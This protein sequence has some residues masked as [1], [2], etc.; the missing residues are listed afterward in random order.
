M[1]D[2]LTRILNG[3]PDG[4]GREALRNILAPIVDRLSCQ[5]TATAG[6]V[7]KA[8]GS[9]LAKTGASAC[10]GMVQGRPFTIDAATD[11]PALA[12][13]ISANK[14]NVFCFFIDLV[15]TRT[16]LMGTEAASRGNVKFPPF[17]EGK[18]L[19]GYLVITH[20]ATFVGGTTAL[21]TATT[22]YVSP[23]GACDPSALV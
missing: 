21:D 23:M 1:N 14:F 9:A 4:S 17:P 3:V 18:T 12:G 6:L 7:I 19:V 5:V 22:E 15:G 8:G 2:T 13:S 11:M 16:V 10:H 20:N